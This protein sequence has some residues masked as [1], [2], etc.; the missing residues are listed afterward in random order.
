[1]DDKTKRELAE[2]DP[3]F[4]NGAVEDGKKDMI[5]KQ[6]LPVWASTQPF[7]YEGSPSDAQAVGGDTAGS[8]AIDAG[9]DSAERDRIGPAGD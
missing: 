2:H 9:E 3:D 4:T 5:D 8:P 7:G 6:V 1:M